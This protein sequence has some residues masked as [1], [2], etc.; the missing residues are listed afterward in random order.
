MGDRSKI[1]WTDATWN[2]ITGC[3]PVSEG[4]ENCYAKREAEGR[5]RGRAGYDKDEPFKVTFHPG[6]LDQPLH[7]SKPRRIFVCSMG[8]L[9]HEDVPLRWVNEVFLTIQK[10][11]K[12]TFIILTKRPDR[13]QR[14]MKLLLEIRRWPE[15]DIPF[16]N[17]WLGVTAENQQRADERIPILLDTPAA[18]R[19][20]SVEPMLGPVELSPWD[21]CDLCGKLRNSFD[22]DKVLGTWGSSF[23]HEHYNP[24]NGCEGTYTRHAIDW[25]IC[26]GETGRE[27]RPM[28]PDWARSL[29][30]QSTAAK[31]PFFFKSW[32]EWF[33][34]EDGA[35]AC[36]VC[37]CT[38]NNAC[39]GGCW[40]VEDDLCSSCVGK[41][42]SAGDRPVKFWRLGKRTSGRLLDGRTWDEYPTCVKE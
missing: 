4:C 15:D 42:V 7:W 27:A 23:C 24:F 11:P 39:E 30:D 13:M 26:G 18:V 32:G 31:V 28:H 38:E 35:R 9:F 16:P 22:P 10:A 36:R 2:P 20:V 1:E 6:K 8:D 41:V 17:L 29:R 14:Y 12:H 34:P 25:L 21:K 19:F 40:W 33:V 37:G 5:L 3:S